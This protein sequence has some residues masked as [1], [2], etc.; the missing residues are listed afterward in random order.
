MASV[1][2]VFSFLRHTCIQYLH[3]QQGAVCTY[4]VREPPLNTRDDKNE[5]VVLFRALPNMIDTSGK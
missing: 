3:I 1:Y 4:L 5:E 2:M